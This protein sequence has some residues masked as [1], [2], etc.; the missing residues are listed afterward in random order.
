MSLPKHSTCCSCGYTSPKVEAGGIHYCPNPACSVCGAT[1]F[2][3]DFDSYREDGF[4]S[5]TVDDEEYLQKA[6]EYLETCP[7]TELAIL[8]D[9]CLASWAEK[10]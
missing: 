7:D 2:R 1:W 4:S 6:T 3:R 10:D 9:L 8:G 5:Y